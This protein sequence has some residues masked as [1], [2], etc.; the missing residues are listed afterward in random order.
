M[1]LEAWIGRTIRATDR[2]DEG[3][4]RRWCATFDRA[5]PSPA[6]MP[7]GI[8]FALCTPDAQTRALG[9]DGHPERDDTADSFLP[10]FPMPRRMW[11]SSTIE[12]RK[13]IAVG[14]VIER[15]SR[16]ASIKQKEGSSGRLA[17]VEVAHETS[18]DG[19]LAVIETQTLV[20][21]EAAAA[22]APLAP[23]KPE[24]GRF[25]KSE[26][27]AHTALTPDPRLLFRYS[28]LTFN[29]HR[30]HYDAL[31]ARGVERYRGL[32]VHGPLIASLLL[33]LAAREVGENRLR[34]FAFRGMSPAIAGDLLHLAMRESADGLELGA[35][36]AD[37]RQVTAASASL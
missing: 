34:R 28:A 5:L 37:G 20:Y 21:R 1:N 35:F 13:P 9:D 15:V 12:F 27:T 22:D 7:L 26:W 4:A 33:Q 10:P 2:L 32:V 16:V 14:A 36:A 31:Y 6:I 30:I 11:A 19:S 23:P 8:H 29:T 25:E 18:A 24:S 17:F 3:L